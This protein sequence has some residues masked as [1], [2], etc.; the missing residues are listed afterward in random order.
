M[1]SGPC[2]SLDRS[3]SE[4]LLL[5]VNESRPEFCSR[6]VMNGCMGTPNDEGFDACMLG[7]RAVDLLPNLS[8]LLFLRCEYS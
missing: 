2:E 1:V 8:T 6:T 5:C 4:V 7:A 3:D